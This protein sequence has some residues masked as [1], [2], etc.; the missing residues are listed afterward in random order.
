MAIS[1]LF[2]KDKIERLNQECLRL[3]EKLDEKE[4]EAHKYEED[5]ASIRQLFEAAT[6]E[7]AAVEVSLKT[8][9]DK[10]DA[11]E[12]V[13]RS[14][15]EEN[16]EL[17]RKKLRLE[18]EYRAITKLVEEQNIIL[19]ADDGK[20]IVDL[21]DYIKELTSR[22]GT[23][24]KDVK[25]I[26]LDY[27]SKYRKVKALD[28]E[29]EEKQNSLIE[30]EEALLLQDVGLYTPQYSFANSTDYK[31][32]L[33]ECRNK[34]K[35]LIKGK[36]AAICN[37]K[38]S[39]NGDLAQ[40]RKMVNDKIKEAVLMFNT[41]C[42]NAIDKVKYSNYESM[43]KRIDRMFEKLNRLN[44]TQDIR[45]TTEYLALKH[46][47]LALAFEYAMKVQEE[48]EYIREQRE[49]E[50]ENAKVQ[51][52]I[53]EER[54]R[55]AKEKA[56]YENVLHR[57]QEQLEETITD[58]EKYEAITERIADVD[59]ELSS[60]EEALKQVDY[61][62]ANERAGYVYVI[63][64]IG[65]FGDNIY[66]IG[67]TRRLD[68][69]ERI[70]ELSTASVPFPYDVHALVFSADAPKLES[71]LHNAFAEYRVNRVNTRKE[72]FKVPL[73][74]IERVVR[75]NHDR[76]VDFQYIPAAE[77]YRETKAMEKAFKA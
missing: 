59:N 57:L 75:E 76:T 43:K 58:P 38:W 74:E 26:G 60:L 25:R 66:K 11:L 47:E 5:C 4:A 28:A 36:K 50:R 42:E 2:N 10:Y 68:P 37:T 13:N 69:M 73:E 77:Q 52:E 8:T 31:S 33:E 27:L 55:I 23:L 72:F 9:N 24:E 51:K 67:M 19:S 49:I 65:A 64:N 63:S 34:Q 35:E 61:R 53:E 29:L 45:I 54:K 1:D 15:I 7:K 46:E 6:S 40:G 16:E 30:L 56:H 62:Q 41:E 39:V 3:K 32:R 22:I 70:A 21:R 48:K 20:K 18:E 17:K 44:E 14:L 71:A 12:K